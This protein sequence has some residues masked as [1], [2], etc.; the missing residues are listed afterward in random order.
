M[1]KYTCLLFKFADPIGFPWEKNHYIAL[2]DFG[3]IKENLTK[4]IP[5]AFMQTM[6]GKG[7]VFSSQCI[8]NR[9]FYRL[10]KLMNY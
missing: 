3:S 5:L 4:G 10:K 8:M 2:G 6:F 9:Y 7:L 1:A